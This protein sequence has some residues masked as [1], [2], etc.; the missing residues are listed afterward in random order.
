MGVDEQQDPVP[1]A[2]QANRNHVHI[3]GETDFLYPQKP[4]RFRMSRSRQPFNKNLRKIGTIS[5]L[6]RLDLP[7]SASHQQTPF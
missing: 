7:K 6:P 1:N 4:V 5:P 3:P 2:S